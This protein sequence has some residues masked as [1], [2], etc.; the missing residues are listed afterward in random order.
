MT[1]EDAI[2]LGMYCQSLMED[3]RFTNLVKVCEANFSLQMLEE[4][5]S[6]EREK[7]F[8]TYQ[9]LKT[10]L[11]LMQQFVIVKDQIVAR[12]EQE[13]TKE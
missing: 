1:E 8:Y 13:D 3:A 4:S 11:E 12:M 7:T 2:D 9:G 5:S 10:L 6:E